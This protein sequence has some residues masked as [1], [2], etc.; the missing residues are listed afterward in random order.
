[1]AARSVRADGQVAE[2]LVDLL[3]AVT[4]A[5][6]AVASVLVHD[7]TV[8]VA[9]PPPNA[10]LVGLALASSLPLALRRRWPSAVLVLS[11]GSW[12]VIDLL[13]WNNGVV[14]ACVT[15]A[16]YASASWQRLRFALVCLF[17]LYAAFAVV[18]AVRHDSFADPL[19]YITLTGFTV[20]WVAGLSVRRL[21]RRQREAVERALEAERTRAATA[22]RAVFAERLRIARELHD[23]VSHTLSVIAVQSAV[24]R[25]LLP[26]DSAAIGPALAT[27][28]EASRTALDDLRRMLGVLRTDSGGESSGLVPSPGLD[29]LELLI[30]AHR[31]A[32]GP[33]DLDVDPAVAAMPESLRLTAYRLVQEALTNVRKHAPGAHTQVSVRAVGGDLEVCIDDDGAPTVSTAVKTSAAPGYGLAG[34]RERV[35]MFGGVLEAGPGDERGFRVRAILHS[36][37]NRTAVA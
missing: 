15:F 16:I 34:M 5:V 14:P 22:E 31:A 1:M 13:G 37:A 2:W 20:I 19:M 24:A 9:Y 27:I 28:E 18:T 17:L 12:A 10:A 32:H 35:T 6:L 36:A 29:E 3:L 8:A 11:L 26:P 25:H 30:S 7:P 23:V 4:L 33:V 21:R